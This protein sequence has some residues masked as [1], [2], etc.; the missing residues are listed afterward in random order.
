MSNYD[1]IP[2]SDKT[3][4]GMS[5]NNDDQHF[6]K[7]LFDRQDQVMDDKLDA[8]RKL[9]SQQYELILKVQRV[10]SVIQNEICD[11]ET[12]I[13]KLEDKVESIESKIA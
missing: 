8:I 4:A 11:H 2:I 3:K 9:V 7:R 13:K 1:N 12:R 6:L 10:I 5:F